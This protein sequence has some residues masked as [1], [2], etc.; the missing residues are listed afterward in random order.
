M[1]VTASYDGKRLRERREA[2][3]WRPEDLAHHAD[4]SAQQIRNLEEGRTRK[5]RSLT[6]KAIE[7]AL[8]AGEGVDR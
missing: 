4:V 6:V 7:A 1:M 2:L 5:P 3:G 8:A